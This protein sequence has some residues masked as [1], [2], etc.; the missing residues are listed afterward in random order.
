MI[1]LAANTIEHNISKQLKSH[2]KTVSAKVISIH[3]YTKAEVQDWTMNHY[4]GSQV[5]KYCLLALWEMESG[6]SWTVK[7][8]DRGG[9]AYGIPQ[10]KPAA[11]MANSGKDWRTN[12]ITQVRWGLRY[13]ELRY[14][15]HAQW[16]LRHEMKY[17]WY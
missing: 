14:N 17:G 5:D 8:V 10:A 9:M 13:I 2:T 11:K 1:C 15:G 6:W 16:A 3:R 12:P 4:K 7:A